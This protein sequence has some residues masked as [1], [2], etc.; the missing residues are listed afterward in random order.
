MNQVTS[1]LAAPVALPQVDAC[2]R[3]LRVYVHVLLSSSYQ[4]IFTHTHVYICIF[5]AC[6]LPLA[7]RGDRMELSSPDLAAPIT[8]TVG[9]ETL[10]WMPIIVM[11]HG[12][13]MK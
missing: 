11:F 12:H 6:T 13:T 10:L 3:I 8:Y 7:K 4:S 5:S 2:L 9:Y 1:G